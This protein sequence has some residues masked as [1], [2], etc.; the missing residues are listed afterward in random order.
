MCTP[1]S[2]QWRSRKNISYHHIFWDT[3]LLNLK[4]TVSLGW[5]VPIWLTVSATNTWVTERYSHGRLSCGYC[6]FEV[7][8]SRLYTQCFYKAKHPWDW[9]L[10]FICDKIGSILIIDN[11]CTMSIFFVQTTLL[12]WNL[13]GDT[14]KEWSTNIII[15]CYSAHNC[16][17]LSNKFYNC[18]WLPCQFAA[19]LST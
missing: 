16:E 15:Q 14:N 12:L 4:F 17:L 3:F 8:L 5:L 13:L 18:L 9:D 1:E 19:E 2:T 6:L 11:R 7:G 10:Y